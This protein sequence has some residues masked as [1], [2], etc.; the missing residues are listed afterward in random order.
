MWSRCTSMTSASRSTCFRT[1]S[2]STVGE[3]PVPELRRDPVTGRWVA[4]ATERHKRPNDFRVERMTVLPAD[5]CPFCPGHEDM[6][7]PEIYAHRGNGSGPNTSGWDIRV[8][9]NKFPALRV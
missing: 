7:P 4:V 8:I 9:P 3:K 1:H 5:Q 6:T 2:T